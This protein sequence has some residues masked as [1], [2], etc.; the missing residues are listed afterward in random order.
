MDYTFFWMNGGSALDDPYCYRDVRNIEAE[1]RVH[2][3]LS[4]NQM[5]VLTA[6]GIM[7]I[8][9]LYQLYADK[10]AGTT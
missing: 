10:L 5:R 4:A 7:R 2:E 8:N 3:V 9:T 1:E 6:I